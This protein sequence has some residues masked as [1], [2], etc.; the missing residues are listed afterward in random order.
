M[1]PNERLYIT[2]Y[3]KKSSNQ[4]DYYLFMSDRK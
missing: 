2:I 3:H 4:S 1:Y